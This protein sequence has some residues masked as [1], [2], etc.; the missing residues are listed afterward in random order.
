[1]LASSALAM[2]SAALAFAG[3]V[4]LGSTSARAQERFAE[5]PTTGLDL[6]AQGLA[7][8][9]GATAVDRNPAGLLYLG[10]F[11]LDGVFTGLDADHADGPGTG[12]GF[13]AG[14]PIRA[15]FVPPMAFGVAVEKF[16]P[17]R[18]QVAPDPGEP[19]RFSL[20]AALPVGPGSLGAAWRHFVDD[21]G[22][23][24][25]GTDTFDLG[26]AARM[27]ARWAFGVVARDLLSPT[28]GLAPVQRRYA[29]ELVSRPLAT[30]RLTLAVGAEIGERRGDVDPRVR[31]GWRVG[32]G[33]WLHGEVAGLT[34]W[35]LDNP[36][37][38]TGD[39]DRRYE[40]R[41]SLGVEL[42]FGGVGAQ[43]FATAS[44]DT[45]E[46]AQLLGG[47]VMVRW[48]EEQSPRLQGRP[49]YV[50]RIRLEG[51]M[52]VREITGV[53]LR[54][55][56]ISRDANAVGVLLS[57]DGFAAG[58][59]TFD[60]LRDAVSE[61]RRRGKKVFVHMVQGGTRD[62]Y[63]ASAADRIYLDPAGG[64][65]LVGMAS[66]LLFFKQLFD[67]LGVNA[68][69]VKIDEFK[70]APE[71]WTRAEPS[72]E[73]RAM[74]DWILDSLYGTVVTRIAEGR[75]R[76]VAEIRE[77][78]ENGPY[79]AGEAA[80]R[81]LVDA[82]GEPRE[83]DRLIERELGR[84]F[85]VR[86]GPPNERPPTW[87]YPQLAIVYIDGDIVDGKSRRIPVLARALVGGDTIAEALA[88]ARANPR[89]KAIVVRIDSPGGSAVASE[90]IAREVF[91]TRGVKPIVVS[92]GDIAASGGYFAA[93]GGDMI[94]AEPTSLTGSIGIFYGKFDISGLLRK[95][96]IT[97]E[98]TL[99]GARADMESF[100]RPYTAEELAR[101]GD[102]L[103]YFY[104]RF[105]G[106][107]AKGRHM[108]PAAVDKVGRGQVF[109]G[110]QAKER[111]LIDRFGGLL[112]AI[113]EAKRRAGYGEDDRLEIVM[114]PREP[115][116]LL[117]RLLELGSGG[118]VSTPVSPLG[119]GL[120]LVDELLG[121]L[122]GSLL[123]G[124]ERPQ[125]RLPFDLRVGD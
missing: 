123:V 97:W 118:R 92:M 27:G 93:V 48:S 100:Y 1:M 110:T 18:A 90:L 84:G 64:L 99:R 85:V 89:I 15:P 31:F 58:W 95:L 51:G 32:R 62:Y 68:Q 61:L 72:P 124:P 80:R 33:A 50:A 41:S 24:L 43:A 16:L 19:V 125:A 45:R 74:R 86:S 3:V 101:L 7:G 37:F 30:D 39:A 40:W 103:R 75:R 67:L 46:Q 105:V 102:A 120:P 38:P 49:R 81:G 109:T 60:E 2:L 73:A 83:I 119:T 78:I 36:A 10:G 34:R 71:A 122:P 114:L 94:F 88:W 111:K 115:K 28:V 116:H 17:P 55:R 121:S 47:T 66:T 108:T 98:T 63:L 26:F 35:E 5:D 104:D 82:V 69:F 117:A 76:T 54:L 22:G 96:G 20:A 52:Q 91:Q 4:S 8:D 14:V 77:L 29:L 25:D 13:Y 87:A 23:A 107:V 42:S 9:H 53:L 112:A 70:T 59:A 79:T 12:I 44:F 11:Q 57:L 21:G 106:A 6:P 56:H 113:D 65:R